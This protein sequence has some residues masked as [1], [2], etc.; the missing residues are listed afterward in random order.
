MVQKGKP[1]GTV[2]RRPTG[3]KPG[4]LA[5]QYPRVTLRLPPETLQDLDAISRAVG[6]PQWQIVYEAV[7]AFVGTGPALSNDDVRAVREVLRRD[8]KA[9]RAGPAG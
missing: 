9:E 6:R 1:R 2:G 8:T 4:E 5:S 3:L 7:R